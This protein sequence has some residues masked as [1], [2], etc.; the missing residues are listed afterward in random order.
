MIIPNLLKTI[1]KA[2]AKEGGKA[3]VVGGYVRDQI[4]GSEVISK[5]IDV[6]VYGL[7]NMETLISILESFGKPN[8][9]GKSFGVIKLDSDDYFFDFSLP[10]REN[11][12]GID[13]KA[14][15]VTT[16]ASLGF[17]EAFR[18]RDF[19]IN[20][21]GYDVLNEATI[22]P[23]GGVEDCHNRVLRVVDSQT[24]VEDPLRFY[25]A[26]QFIARFDLRV[27][28]KSENLL[29]S[30]VDHGLLDHISSER[31]FE[32]FNKLL[33]K[34]KRPSIGFEWLKK[35]GAL[36][37]YFPE[38]DQLIGVEQDKQWHPEGDVYIHTMMALDQMAK[39]K[40]KSLLYM[41][42]L[43]CHDFGKVSTTQRLEN[44]RITSHGHEEAGEDPTR[45]F[46]A[47]LTNNKRLIEEVVILVR[48]HL[49]PAML[50]YNKAKD[51]AI[52]RLAKKVA[53]LTLRDVAIVNLADSLGRALDPNPVPQFEWLLQKSETLCVNE[54]PEKPI[55]TGKYL[56]TLGLTPSPT[57]KTVLDQCESLQLDGVI[58]KENYQTVVTKAFVEAL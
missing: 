8:S 27:D 49:R 14:Y 33:L 42:A 10:R 17:D 37:R 57:F 53:P 25:R 11:S 31:I 6:E 7:E 23:Y 12:I 47:R 32:E 24:F 34:A 20:A 39:M 21:I 22:D 43:L 1:V 5:D 15:K 9:V 29:R 51:G 38:V 2:I 16:D 13:H 55:I 58:T 45:A 3:I 44:G 28:Q 50:Y 52:K 4:F 40:E 30:M 35:L 26:V 54:R 41:Y 36:E 46:M 56:I 18:R 48:F 19:T